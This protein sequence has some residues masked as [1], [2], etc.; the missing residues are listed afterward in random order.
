MTH[1]HD[2]CGESAAG[3]SVVRG[4]FVTGTD[5]GVGKTVAACAIVAALRGAG[6]PVRVMKPVETGVG[7]AGPLDAI[8]LSAAAGDPDPLIDVC[9]LRFALPAAPNVAAHA[10]ARVVDLELV[11]AAWRR[12]AARGGPVVVEGAGGLLAPLTD[13]LA[14]ADLG[15]E[16]G[17]P[18]V[19]VA[20]GALGTINHTRLTLAE[21]QRRQLPLAG[22]IVSVGAASLSDADATNLGFLC[23]EL[24]ERLLGVIP[25]LA[26]GAP[27]PPDLLDPGRWLAAS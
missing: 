14:M 13:E 1:A 2:A 4:F 23:A 16:L 25:T 11:R 26:T 24:G 15:E 22:V 5:T 27:V 6:E 9:P 17:L 7:L 10:E 21:I 20:R 18:F 19:V 8:A 12:L 3:E